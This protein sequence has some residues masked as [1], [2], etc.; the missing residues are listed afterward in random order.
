MRGTD[1]VRDQLLGCLAI[2]VGS[3]FCFRGYPTMRLVIP[4]WGAFSGFLVGAGLVNR[5]TGDGFLAGALTWLA[6]IA[7]AV[8]FGLVAYTHY[9]V[10]AVLA[11]AAVGFVL[12][13]SLVVGLNFSWSWVA[14][15]VGVPVG[16]VLQLR[17]LD[18]VRRSVREQWAR[19]GGWQL[20]RRERA[21]Q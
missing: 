21:P 8:I 15:V 9:E 3:L 12:G 14:V 11:I 13:A 2:I 5:L 19:D 10:S 17:F 6:G 16:L 20:H 1:A 7:V 4:V 18:D